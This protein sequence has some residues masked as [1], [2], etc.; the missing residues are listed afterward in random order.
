MQGLEKEGMIFISLK[1]EKEGRA[2][3][4]LYQNGADGKIKQKTVEKTK[5]EQ[6]P[7]S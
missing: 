7:G 2:W 3:R 6:T 4:N 1:K 5:S